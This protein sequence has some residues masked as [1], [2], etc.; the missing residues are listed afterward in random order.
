M[1]Q[2]RNRPRFGLWWRVFSDDDTFSPWP[3]NTAT[4]TFVVLVPIALLIWVSEPT[5]MTF[6][7]MLV[8]SVMLYA[9]ATY[10]TGTIGRLLTGPALV[11]GIG[12]FGWV[13]GMTGM[14][15]RE[16]VYFQTMGAVLTVYVAVAFLISARMLWKAR[17]ADTLAL[18]VMCALVGLAGNYYGGQ[19]ASGIIGI[20]FIQLAEAVDTSTVIGVFDGCFIAVLLVCAG[21]AIVYLSRLAESVAG[22]SEEHTSEL[23]SRI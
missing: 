3:R 6:F 1:E 2:V 12:T 5:I 13:V 9:F 22:R 18:C 4:L 16:G 14:P 17:R 10:L 21:L 15:M 8:L 23:Q 19:A 20:G 11:F 7:T